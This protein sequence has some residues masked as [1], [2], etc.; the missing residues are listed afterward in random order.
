MFATKA[1]PTRLVTALVAGLSLPAHALAAGCATDA[2]LVFDGSGSMIEYGFD[3]RQV[4]RIKEARQAVAT[5]LPQVEDFRRIGLLIYGPNTGD[6]CSGLDLRFAPR[7][8]AAQPIIS[9]VNDLNPG[10]LTPLAASVDVAAQAL[11]H[12]REPGIIVVV[13][14]GNETCGG[15]PCATAD[16]LAAEA[17]DL[18]IHVIGFRA[19][20]DFWTWDNPEQEAH[21]GKGSVARCLADRTGGLYV[22]AD[23]VDTLIE[24]LQVTLGCPLY[25]DTTSP[26]TRRR[27]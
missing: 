10:G 2:M 1:L 7:P 14:D 16:R 12:R 9:A 21:T 27:G 18:T 24:A 25:G 22:S 6:S 23:T 11:D 15:L 3:Y 26:A 4:T 8:Q 20:V 17:R 5:A 19:I 13:T